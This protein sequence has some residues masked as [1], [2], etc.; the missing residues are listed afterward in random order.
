MV[1]LG[2]PVTCDVIITAADVIITAH[3]LVS[4]PLYFLL[5]AHAYIALI[6][7]C[8]V[9]YLSCCFL[10]FFVE[11]VS[12]CLFTG[13]IYD[14][15]RDVQFVEHEVQVVKYMICRASN[16]ALKFKALNTDYMAEIRPMYV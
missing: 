1:S 4:S 15:W 10:F 16:S 7:S 11:E 6:P 5:L 14:T 12:R 13:S 9:E 3:F 8:F 2:S